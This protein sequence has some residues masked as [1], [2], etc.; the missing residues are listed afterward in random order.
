[1][2]IFLIIGASGSGK[3]SIS[4]EMQ[5]RDMWKECIS[6]T[7]RPMREKDGERDGVTYYFIDEKLFEQKLNNGDFAEFVEYDGNKYGISH[8][9]IDRVVDSGKHVFIIVDHNGYEQVKALYHDAVSIFLYMSKEDCMLNMLKRGD[10]VEKVINR[11]N[12]YDSELKNKGDYDY[13]IK[14]VNGKQEE[15][16]SVISSIVLQYS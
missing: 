10:K 14:N 1:V 8:A 3:T 15:V 4:Q 9:E 12:L 5:E 16:I 2:A 13:V 11:I 7:T 6:H